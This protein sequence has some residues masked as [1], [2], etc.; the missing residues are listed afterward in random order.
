[1]ITPIL[2]EEQQIILQSFLIRQ[3]ELWRQY[4][5]EYPGVLDLASYHIAPDGAW[6]SVEHEHHRELNLTNPAREHDTVTVIRLS[7]AC[8]HLVTKI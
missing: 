4:Q 7:P 3:T 1:M 2:T 5:R 6:I 8:S